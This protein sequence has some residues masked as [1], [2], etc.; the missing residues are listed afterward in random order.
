MNELYIVYC[1][2]LK[3]L[4]IALLPAQGKANWSQL[5][6]TSFLRHQLMPNEFHLQG[7]WMQLVLSQSVSLNS[8]R[9]Q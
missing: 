4:I 3:F 8:S 7:D 1:T 9:L 6:F 5:Y 2:Q